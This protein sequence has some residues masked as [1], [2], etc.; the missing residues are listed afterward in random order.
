MLK[1]TFLIFLFMFFIVVS[2]EAQN[3]GL[4]GNG[5]VVYEDKNSRGR[6]QRFGIGRFLNGAGEFGNLRNDKASS[7][8]VRRGYRIR[9]CEDEGNG[10]GSGKCEEYGSGNYNL[11]YSDKASYIEVRRSGGGNWGDNNWGGGNDSWV[12]GTWRWRNGYDRRTMIIN[13]NG[14]VTVNANGTT[15]NGTYSNGTLFLGNSRATLTRQGNKLKV[16]IANSNEVFIWT[17]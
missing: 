13:R 8:S 3:D 15:T 1:N 9:L 14:N 7:V 4:G 16:D 12:Y 2:T 17:R 5:A 10:N 6:S 11:R